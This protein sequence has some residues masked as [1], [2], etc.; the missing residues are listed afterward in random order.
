MPTVRIR[1]K[2]IRSAWIF[3]PGRA[4]LAAEVFGASYSKVVLLEE[5]VGVDVD[6]D[7]DFGAPFDRGKPVADH[8][9]DV[10]RAAG[11]NEQALAVA[12]AKHGERR[13]GRT[14]DRHAFDFGRGMADA[15]GDGFG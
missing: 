6:A 13:W 8:V 14:E 2:S 9:L 4:Q 11:V 3:F 1:T 7:P 5:A 15:A 12:A 10:E